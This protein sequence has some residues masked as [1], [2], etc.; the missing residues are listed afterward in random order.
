M[1]F[2]GQKYISASITF[3]PL[4]SNFSPS[5]QLQKIVLVDYTIIPPDHRHPRREVRPRSFQIS[6]HFSSLR[7]PGYLDMSL[8]SYQF[9]LKFL[10]GFMFHP[11]YS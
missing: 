4:L 10:V 8:F 5:L 2:Q 9:L 7:V 3:Y 11:L 1:C 6:N